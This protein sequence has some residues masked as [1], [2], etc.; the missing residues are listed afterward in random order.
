MGI[1]EVTT[2]LGNTKR[3][4]VPALFSGDGVTLILSGVIGSRRGV[5][6]GGISDFSVWHF[7]IGFAGLSYRDAT[8]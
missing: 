8:P 6:N 7:S 5:I 4:K 3:Q 2:T 1:K